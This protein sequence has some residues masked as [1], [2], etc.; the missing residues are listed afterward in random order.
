MPDDDQ[1]LSQAN[2]SAHQVSSASSCSPASPEKAAPTSSFPPRRL[3]RATSFSS[4]VPRPASLDPQVRAIGHV[5]SAHVASVAV[6]LDVIVLTRD[7]GHLDVVPAR[8]VR[9]LE[10][11]GYNGSRSGPMKR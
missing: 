5:S 8:R 3:P 10:E 1:E 6:A 4:N 11:E 7:D 9:D 2:P